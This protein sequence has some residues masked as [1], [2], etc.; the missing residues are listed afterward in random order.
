MKKT[1]ILIT[2]LSWAVASFSQGTKDPKAKKIMD[3]SLVKVRAAKSFTANFKVVKHVPDLGD[4]KSEG[5][6]KYKED[7]IYLN[8]DDGRQVYNDGKTLSVFYKED[9][10]VNIYT[11]D[12]EENDD[13]NIDKYLNNY[14]KNYKYV[15]LGTQQVDGV[16]CH[17]IELAPDKSPE[18]LKRVSVFKIK[19]FIRI[20]DDLVI[21]WQNFERTG[22][23]Y[24]TTISNFEANIDLPDE[25]FVFDPKQ[26]PDV[27][28]I[29][30]RE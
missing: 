14:Q 27:E 21:K 15:Y 11:S 7:K 22:V 25:T 12:P 29:D 4:E 19:L 24:T 6:V 10:E 5:N 2:F 3:R 23:Y 28:I 16:D 17:Q 30:M 26:H 1:A 20:A 9:N 18:D 8:S 13:F